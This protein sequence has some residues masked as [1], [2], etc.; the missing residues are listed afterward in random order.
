[1]NKSE[2]DVKTQCNS[3]SITILQYKTPRAQIV[4]ILLF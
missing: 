3:V 1:M 2:V 4:K